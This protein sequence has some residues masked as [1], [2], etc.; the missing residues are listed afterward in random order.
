MMPTDLF[1]VHQTQR[2]QTLR[3]YTETLQSTE[4]YKL[5]HKA[6]KQQRTGH[7]KSQ[8]KGVTTSQISG[9]AATSAATL[10]IH[11][12]SQHA[13]GDASSVIKVSNL[14]YFSVFEIK[15]LIGFPSMTLRNVIVIDVCC[16]Y[17]WKR[18]ESDIGRGT[19]RGG[20][21][22]S[23]LLL[24]FQSEVVCWGTV[25]FIKSAIY[26]KGEKII[27]VCV[28]DGSLSRE[29]CRKQ[30]KIWAETGSLYSTMR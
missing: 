27:P 2:H 11:Y 25:W 17:Q 7:F 4:H 5:K 8:H 23:K 26:G 12:I 1:K 9:H 21:V 10:Q 19:H 3:C 14:T 15:H 30:V 29:Q 13:C 18:R 24:L 20:H 22:G 6:Q 28:S 16:W